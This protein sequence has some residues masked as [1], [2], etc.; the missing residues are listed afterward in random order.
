MTT[1]LRVP[2]LVLHPLPR[3]MNLERNR[4]L[5][6][7]KTI[8]HHHTNLRL[9]H[10]LFCL[11]VLLQRRKLRLTFLKQL[12]N[13]KRTYNAHIVHSFAPK[14][15]SKH[16]PTLW[17]NYIKKP[18]NSFLIYVKSI[19]PQSSVLLKILILQQQ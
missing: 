6:P 4:R 17:K 2:A 19:P 5:L 8:R 13:A 18:N 15:K 9:I 11:V 3:R 14:S 12:V 1:T 7:K 16:L 10:M